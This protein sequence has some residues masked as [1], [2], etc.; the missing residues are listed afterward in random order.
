MFPQDCQEGALNA[1]T[2]IDPENNWPKIPPKK[3][4]K[5]HEYSHNVSRGEEVAGGVNMEGR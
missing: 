4:K 5:K 3:G 2:G 1:E